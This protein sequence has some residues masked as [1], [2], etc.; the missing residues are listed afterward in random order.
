LRIYVAVTSPYPPD[1]G[2]TIPVMLHE[3]LGTP[4]NL[5][6]RKIRALERLAFNDVGLTGL[7]GDIDA[8]HVRDMARNGVVCTGHLWGSL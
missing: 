5:E 4:G 7:V 8:D 6:L 3:L 1:R 2:V